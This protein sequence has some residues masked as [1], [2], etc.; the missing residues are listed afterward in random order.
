MNWWRA[1]H[2]ISAD[3]KLGVVA[4][5]CGARRCEVGWVWTALLDRASQSEERGSIAGY[6]VEA[7]AFA[8]EL[9]AEVVEAIIETM[10]EKGM[11]DSCDILTAWERRQPVDATHAERQK[12]YRDKQKALRNGSDAS[13]DTEEKRR[14]ENTSTTENLS[15]Q[16][17]VSNT[18]EVQKGNSD[19]PDGACAHETAQP[20]PSLVRP[21]VPAKK[22][23]PKPGIKELTAK[24]GDRLPW[25]EAFWEVFPCHDG[26]RDAMEAYERRFHSREEAIAAYRGAQAYRAKSEADPT[27]KLKYGQGWINGERWTDENR[28]TVVPKKESFG[29]FFD[30]LEREAEEKE[31]TSVAG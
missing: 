27:M 5:R 12:R 28:I 17:V 21:H 10:R 19:A 3:A 25:W 24:L 23:S 18:G 29:D 26:K 13:R 8:G 14:E 16:E 15:T 6:D 9:S 31:K 20:S 4:L 7:M 30:R 1:Y 2:G 11:I 22:K